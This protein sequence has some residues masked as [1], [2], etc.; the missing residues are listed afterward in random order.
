MNPRPARVQAP[1]PK[2][3]IP[4]AES[5]AS[6]APRRI[7]IAA[8]R[9]CAHFLPA[10]F[11]VL[12]CAQVAVAQ[13]K[14]ASELWNTYMDAAATSLESE[15]A[16]G[17]RIF[18]QSANQLA[19]TEGPGNPR[20]EMA[21]FLGALLENDTSK[22]DELLKKIGQ[23]LPSSSRTQFLPFGEVMGRVGENYYNR[24]K[25]AESEDERASVLAIAERATRLEIAIRQRVGSEPQGDPSLPNTVGFLGVILFREGKYELACAQY[26]KALKIWDDRAKSEARLAGGSQRF[27][28]FQSFSGTGG[29]ANSPLDVRILLARAYASLASQNEGDKQPAKAL[30]ARRKAEKEYKS[31]LE[32][33][34]HDWPNH[35]TRSYLLLGLADV[36]FAEKRYADAAPLYRSTLEI[37]RELARPRFK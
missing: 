13:L 5:L 35:L 30:E 1:N 12:A 20:L 25:G 6:E 36:Y 31:V 15:D 32:T 29:Q 33:L 14:G 18:V 37:E 27:S 8:C 34:G 28:L 17:A 11:I 7:S 9:L 24:F 23:A 22:A 2:F 16:A 10:L 19:A 3:P 26:E 4:I 21:E